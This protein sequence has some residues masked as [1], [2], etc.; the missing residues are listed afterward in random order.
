MACLVVVFQLTI[1]VAN[2][3]HIVHTIHDG[4]VLCQRFLYP[5]N[6]NFVIFGLENLSCCGIKILCSFSIIGCLKVAAHLFE[7]GLHG[8]DVAVDIFIF[9]KVEQ[10]VIVELGLL[11][12]IDSGKADNIIGFAIFCFHIFHILLIL[13]IAFLGQIFGK[14]VVGLYNIISGCL[15]HRFHPF[16]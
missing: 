4:I 1:R 3:H 6:S 2:H 15:A 9:I 13:C 11:I 14:S 16:V 5:L 8:F 10:G 12:G 7:I